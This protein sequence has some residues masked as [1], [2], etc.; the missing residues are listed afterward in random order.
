MELARMN[1]SERIEKSSKK[2]VLKIP[3]V[4]NFRDLGGYITRDGR[5]VKWGQ[6]YRSGD[7]SRLRPRGLEILSNLDLYAIFDFRS[8]GE[9]ERQPN[10]VPGGLQVI[11][12]PVMDQANQE[13]SQEIRN[14]LMNKDYE[15]F[16]P[17]GILLIPYQQ[18]V[19]DHTPAFKS[20]IH[21]I[22]D[23][24]GAPILWHCK[25]GKDRTGYAA[26]ILLRI[27]GVDLETIFRDYLL[28]NQY[29]KQMDKR[30]FSVFLAGGFKAYRM[31][32]PLMGV[33]L[34][35]LKAAFDTLDEEWGSFDTF[36]RDGLDLSPSEVQHLQDALLE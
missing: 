15:G 1:N 32:K 33:Q 20:F 34:D 21:T 19:I 27:L 9:I 11:H 23:A 10:R 25:S 12:L 14:R 6:L 22:L 31:V 17:T 35:W 5:S 7:L 18:F 2:R 3:G 4:S 28:S 29:A 24:R 30:I 13:I 8:N 26:A 16:D 36:V